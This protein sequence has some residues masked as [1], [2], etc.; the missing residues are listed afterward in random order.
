MKSLYTKA[1]T[2]RRSTAARRYLPIP[3]EPLDK[4][5]T[6]PVFKFWGY[7][8]STLMENALYAKENNGAVPEGFK[9]LIFGIGTN[10]SLIHI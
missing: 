8:V 7:G 4:L 5:S 6:F 10:L 1:E 9:P 2:T 3:R